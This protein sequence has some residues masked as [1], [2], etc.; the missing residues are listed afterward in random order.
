M[1]QGELTIVFDGGGQVF[2]GALE[3][4]VTDG[5]VV[6]APMLSAALP[7]SSEQSRRVL[8]NSLPLVIWHQSHWR[9]RNRKPWALYLRTL[10]L[11]LRDFDSQTRPRV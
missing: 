6:S 7:L 9:G 8:A 11:E 4:F 1:R 3:C 5:V 10:G 2:N